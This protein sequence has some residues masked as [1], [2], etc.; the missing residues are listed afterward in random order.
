MICYQRLI[1]YFDS[2]AS[3]CQL[4]TRGARRV[5]RLRLGRVGYFLYYRVKSDE[6][7]IL[8]IRHASRST[9]PRQ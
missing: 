9:G 7:L 1:C 4:P 2:L 5:R 3:A 6:L 8:S